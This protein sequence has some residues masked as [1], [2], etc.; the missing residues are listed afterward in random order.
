MRLSTKGRYA[1]MA[2]AD[3]AQ[4][5]AANK[6]VSLADIAHRQEISLSYLEQL[7]AKLRRGGLVRSVRGPGGG[8]RLSRPAGELRIAD[9]IVAV[10]EP[11]AAT[12]CKPGSAK[13]CTTQGARCVT[14]DLWEELGRQIHVFLSSVSLADVVEKRVLGRTQPCATAAN[15]SESA[16]AA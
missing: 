9:V 12:R 4:H 7:F 15:N 5:E 10:D 16:R 2:M 11:I 1:V 6:P 14:H 3:L 13:G 8:Y